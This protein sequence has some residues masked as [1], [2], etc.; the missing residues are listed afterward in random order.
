V[1]VHPDPLGP[2]GA[3][4]RAAVDPEAVQPE[5]DEGEVPGGIRAIHDHRRIEQLVT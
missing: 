5:L 2:Q 4:D 1:D 3:K